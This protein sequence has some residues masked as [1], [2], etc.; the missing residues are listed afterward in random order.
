[1]KLINKEHKLI[2][3]TDFVLTVG[4]FETTEIM[5]N[6]DLQWYYY[7][8][9]KYAKFLKR[10]LELGMFIPTD[11]EGNVLEEN[12]LFP[13]N[14]EG[15]KQAVEHA[16][17]YQEAKDRVLFEY[18]DKYAY[19]SIV[20]TRRTIEDLLNLDLTLTENAIRIITN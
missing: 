11:K 17:Q 4:E 9:E 10:P 5:S 18:N 15:S 2:S 8:I 14:M 6:D 20:I 1:M 13:T 16:K 3:M 7:A 19:Q 12:L